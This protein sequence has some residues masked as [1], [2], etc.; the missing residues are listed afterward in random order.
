MAM[1][2]KIWKSKLWL[3]ITI[4]ALVIINWLASLYHTRIDFT[5]EKRF[6]LSKSTKK[7]LRKLDDVVEVKV[8]LKGDFPSGFKKL[9][10]STGEILQEFKEVAG[11]KLE[12]NFVSPDE[13]VPGTNV[14]W[15]DTL[16]SLGLFPINLKSQL[17]NGEQQQLLYPVALIHYKEK[18]M[19][20]R[21]YNGSPLI[22]HKEINSADAMME[23][24][25]ANAIHKISQNEKSLLAYAIGNG[26]PSLYIDTGKDSLAVNLNTYDLTYTLRR[27]YTVFNFNLKTQPLIPDTFKLLMIVKPTQPF[28]DEEK[29]KIDQF[30]MR[31]GKLLMFIDKLNAEMDSLKIK[32]EVIAYD[33]NLEL[34][35]LLF[36]YGARINSDLVMDIQSDRLPFDVNGNG[37]F[38]FLKWNYFPFF[39]SK[40]NSVINKNLGFVSGQF[41]NSIDTVAAEGISK[42]V[43]LSTSGN[44]KRIAT[45]ALISGRENQ[46][47]PN[48]SSFNIPDIPVALLLEG[49]FTSVFS[50]HLSQS[51]NDTLNKYGGVYLQQCL[52]DNKMI[53]VA[54]GDMVLNGVH[55][56]EPIPMGFNSFTIGSQYEL[57]FSNRDFL[58][59]CLDYLINSSNLSEAKAKDYTLRLLDKNKVEEQKTTWQLINIIVPVLLVFLFAVL[60]Q[61]IRKRKYTVN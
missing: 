9:A 12:I 22:N 33:R 54:D 23:F 26:E 5:N 48:D 42:T 30:V 24:E 16:S 51:M 10:N 31:G 47:A 4:V 58:Q 1:V 60:Y 57:Q 19:P 44:G 38:E 18:V 40:S 7:I 8:F 11:N 53:V 61:F 17:K 41:L 43:L 2:N 39:S 34:N 20:V 59:N 29:L 25:F 3:L 27:D 36:K 6:T 50:N 37:Q 45:P 46:M 14:K 56:E 13:E 32:N 28:N 15:G 35:D 52:Y 55:K 21:I 49:K